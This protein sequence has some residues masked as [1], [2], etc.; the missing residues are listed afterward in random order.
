[1]PLTR[2]DALDAW[3]RSLSGPEVEPEGEGPGA[4]STALNY[5][6]RP[7]S[8]VMGG[9][10]GALSDDLTVKEGARQGI[11][12]ERYFGAYD[13]L[14][15]GGFDPDARSTHLTGLALD[16]FNPLDPL[17]YVGLGFTKA[18]KA[19]KALTKFGDG[20]E[21]LGKISSRTEAAAKGLWSPVTFGGHRVAPK[22]LSV[23]VARPLDAVEN[24]IRRTQFVETMGK[25]LGGV[26]KYEAQ[27]P[28]MSSMMQGARR[29]LKIDE[30]Q[31]SA[32]LDGMRDAFLGKGMGEVEADRL[33]EDVMSLVELPETRLA[34]TER[35]LELVEDALAGKHVDWLP[36]GIPVE[37]AEAITQVNFANQR[38]VDRRVGE[39]DVFFKEPDF[40]RP[41]EEFRRMQDEL[42]L[43]KSVQ[44]SRFAGDMPPMDL[45]VKRREEL[46][47][48]VGRIRA[49][50]DDAG[51]EL[52]E[53]Y[54]LQAPVFEEVRD[55]YRNTL[56]GYD[57]D[58]EPPIED[59]VKHM[60][61]GAYGTLPK[62]VKK[63][64]E[65]AEAE[66]SALVAQLTEEGYSGP[67][68]ER[69]LQDA[70]GAKGALSGGAVDS[71]DVLKGDLDAFMSRKYNMTIDEFNV[72]AEAGGMDARFETN[73]LA[74]LSAMRRDANRWKFGHDIHKFVLDRPGWTIGGEDYAA[75]S[76][77]EQQLWKPMEFHMP[78]IKGEKDPFRGK[79]MRTEVE[80]IM[81]SQMKGMGKL[82]TDDGLNGLLGVMS[83]FREWWTAWTLAPFPST[84]ARDL[85]SDMI[86]G[87]MGGLNPAI[88]LVK[89]ATGDSSY[90]ASLAL[91]SRRSNRP[92]IQ[93]IFGGA[94]GNLDGVLGR[95]EARFGEKLSE[96]KLV[97]Y[98]EIE[99]IL[100]PDAVR[101][102]DV[103]K[104]LSSDP[105]VARA[106]K[107]AGR[108][109]KMLSGFTLNPDKSP[110][111]KAGFGVAQTTADFTRGAL[112]LDSFKKILP[113]AKS[114]DDALQYA[115]AHVRRFQ[116]DYTD[117]TQTEREILK[118]IVPFYTFSA[119]NLPLQISE[120]V[121]DPG[122]FS[123]VNR[124]YQGAWGQ[125]DE[126]EVA[127]EDLP[128]WLGDSLGVP[129]NAVEMEDGSK[130]YAIW[131]PRGWLPQTELNELADIFRG[132]ASTQILSRLSPLLKEPFEQML[133]RDAFTMREIE[134]GTIRDVMG[135]PVNRRAGHLLN[136]IRLISEI[137]RT[138]PGGIFTKIGQRLGYWEG[139]RP[140]RW[141]APGPERATRFFTGL[142]I[143]G[144]VPA[145]QQERKIRDAE[146]EANAAQ[147]RAQ[148]A[149]R[150]GQTLEA[151]EFLDQ[152]KALGEK[153]KAA[154]GRLN[155]LR[156]RNA[157]D[158]ARREDGS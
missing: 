34:R 93:G 150:R 73:S 149:L 12:G 8:G 70:L 152:V 157:L 118:N 117:L 79:Y 41:P 151:Q 3:R 18:G 2:N 62:N 128:D 5:L 123:W 22:G 57:P 69:A 87:H 85:V 24:R 61:P 141:T 143:K 17:N 44:V 100:G 7:V 94:Q 126:D 74:I 11:T 88:D 130:Q 108:A 36:E 65:A 20:A 68:L 75:L 25:Y 115:T 89:G 40:S 129:I 64:Q 86:L 19:A 51:P 120:A 67:A 32:E 102:L 136:N 48:E 146:R 101:D 142:N 13:F 153:R 104:V 4:L 122:R 105:L 1:M 60:F 81:S 72:M 144:V 71:S 83:K 145:E 46:Q 119:K 121:T 53:A 107:E 54:R 49:L 158:V 124:L 52:R 78:W 139:E 29:E 111:I 66:R 59:Y 35:S 114:L 137:D 134:D 31:F 47:G 77:G 92:I 96:E 39:L 103:G 6:G 9:L 95:V 38:A 43:L 116:F 109:R 58:V 23:A 140:H 10:F 63:A 30:T 98:L 21:T 147:S 56:R 42:H 27:F 138:D 156:M 50:W 90:L 15:E 125:F 113:E 132:K 26:K 148:Y 84:R 80:A 155:E 14:V 45:L 97:E 106:N 91:N 112:F 28:G 99:G 110:V 133:N 55:I 135:F 154:A 76:R 33:L 37:E 16:V 127:M 82:L 131:T